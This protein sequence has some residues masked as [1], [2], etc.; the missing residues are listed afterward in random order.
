MLR[1]KSSIK[2]LVLVETAK[3]SYMVLIGILAAETIFHSLSTSFNVSVDFHDPICEFLFYCASES[4]VLTEIQYTKGNNN[5]NAPFEL[6]RSFILHIPHRF[7]SPTQL[8][9]ESDS[10]FLS[11]WVVFINVLYCSVY[12]FRERGGMDVMGMSDNFLLNHTPPHPTHSG[13]VSSSNYNN[14][15]RSMR[16]HD[17]QSLNSVAVET[18]FDLA[19]FDASSS[20]NCYWPSAENF[21]HTQT[22]TLC[23]AD[24]LEQWFSTDVQTQTSRNRSV[25]SR[26]Q[27]SRWTDSGSG[28]IPKNHEI[29][30]A[31]WLSHHDASLWLVWQ[32]GKS[33]CDWWAELHFSDVIGWHCELCSTLP[34]YCSTDSDEDVGERVGWREETYYVYMDMPKTVIRQ[35]KRREWTSSA[36]VDPADLTV[37][38]IFSLL[39]NI[40]SNGVPDGAVGNQLG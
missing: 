13:R 17:G 5:G 16:R 23:D 26:Q 34:L 20:G 18:T 9:S 4:L 35:S 21:S 8:E 30:S 36:L 19:N 31:D 22:Q 6:N 1:V 14:E 33:M 29:S 38:V 10:R 24:T 39:T 37:E 25:V 12:C 40:L 27:Q 15:W 3:W 2:S 32:A 11:D 28:A 7:L